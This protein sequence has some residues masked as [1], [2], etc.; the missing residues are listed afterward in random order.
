M[1]RQR[2]PGLGARCRADAARRG[3]AACVERVR[4]A[5]A[6]ANDSGVSAKWVRGAG[7]L[8]AVASATTAE[9]GEMRA[10][11]NAYAI[12]PVSGEIRA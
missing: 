9:H 12:F 3:D 5:C 6:S 1:R 8:R 4:V 7:E 2:V 11:K 10:K